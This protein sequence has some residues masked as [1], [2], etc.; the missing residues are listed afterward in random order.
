MEYQDMVVS[1][2]QNVLENGYGP[3]R[4]EPSLKDVFA[5]FYD[6]EYFPTFTEFSGFFND[7]IYL[8]R[9][10]ITIETFLIEANSRGL[11]TNKRVYVHVVGLGLGVWMLVPKIQQRIYLEA[12]HNSLMKLRLPFIACIDF[13]WFDP[14]EK[15]SSLGHGRKFQGTDISIR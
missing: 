5:K 2:T 6:I 4:T 7:S 11:K 3:C 9:I 14:N 1:S 15:V 10:Q 12:F 13:S 8:R